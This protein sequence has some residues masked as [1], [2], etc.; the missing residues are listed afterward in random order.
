VL[1]THELALGHRLAKRELCVPERTKSAFNDGRVVAID[2][3]RKCAATDDELVL[4]APDHSGS[5]AQPANTC[6]AAG[7]SIVRLLQP[8]GLPA[9]SHAAATARGAETKRKRAANR[10][11]RRRA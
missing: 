7:A 3:A 11:R 9:R 10:Q 4:V 1:A 8:D 5:P 2:E 6:C